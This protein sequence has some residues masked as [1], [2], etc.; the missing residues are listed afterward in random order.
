MRT[1]TSS[2]PGLPDLAAALCRSAGEPA[3]SAHAALPLLCS[4][5]RTARGRETPLGSPVPEGPPEVRWLSPLCPPALC[6]GAPAAAPERWYRFY[7]SR[8]QR[9]GRCWSRGLRCCWGRLGP[10][11][12]V[13]DPARLPSCRSCPLLLEPRLVW[14]VI[15]TLAFRTHQW[16][17]P[18]GQGLCDS[19]VSEQQREQVFID[20]FGS[21][22]QSASG[23]QTVP[24]IAG[25]LPVF[26]PQRVGWAG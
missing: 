24:F 23:F 6:S 1:D 5:H 7:S 22:N 16:P 18:G 12:Q 9:D 11:E 26:A 21:D 10:A 8:A 20:P 15:S 2:S 25:F 19:W 4:A 14:S 3:H 17:S 13:Q